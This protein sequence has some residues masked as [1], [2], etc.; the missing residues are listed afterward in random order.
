MSLENRIES[1]RNRHAGL[2]VR[3]VAEDLRPMPDSEALAQLKRE[4]LR[5]KEEMER[6]RA[7][8]VQR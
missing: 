3:I 7:S 4:K 6:M 5:V 2:D 1:L 8:K